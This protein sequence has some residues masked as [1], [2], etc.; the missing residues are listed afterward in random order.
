[1][2]VYTCSSESVLAEYIP[3]SNPKLKIYEH[4]DIPC[5]L[6][7]T[8]THDLERL[9]EKVN[10]NSLANGFCLST[11]QNVHANLSSC[12]ENINCHLAY[13]A[14]FSIIVC[15]QKMESAL[16]EY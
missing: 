11:L 3:F 13:V 2:K 15:N 4:V 6:F 5:T 10:I 14:S 16:K 7:L 9:K 8:L 1:M 12:S